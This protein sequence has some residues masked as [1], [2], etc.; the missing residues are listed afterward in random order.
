MDEQKDLEQLMHTIFEADKL[1]SPSLNFTSEVIQKVE[2][3]RK[4]RFA[5][6]PLLPKWVFGT[7]AILVISFVLY[8]MKDMD[9]GVSQVNYFESLNFSTSWITERLSGLNLSKNL[10]YS[11]LAFGVL[12]FVQAG[13]LNKY[14]YRTNTLA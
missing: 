5:Y 14:L 10:G 9:L 8:T 13:L 11:I 3:Q 2:A 4:E 12:V 1:D 7:L 6:T